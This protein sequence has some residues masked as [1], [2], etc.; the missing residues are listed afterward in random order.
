MRKLL[1]VSLAAF[2]GSL[3]A[4]LLVGIPLAVRAGPGGGTASE[5][6]DTNGDGTLDISD[7]VYLL[8]HLFKGGPAPAACADSPELV[9]RVEALEQQ[10]QQIGAMVDMLSTTVSAAKERPLLFAVNSI[11]GP[12]G[13]LC[14][15]D[16]Q[17]YPQVFEAPFV[18]DRPGNL[19]LTI[20]AQVSTTDLPNY[21]MPRLDGGLSTGYPIGTLS[22]DALVGRG[23]SAFFLT[24]VIPGGLPGVHTLRLDAFTERC[25]RSFWAGVSSSLVTLEYLDHQ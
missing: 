23:N 13:P 11:S 22:S 1:I 19:L 21:I 24:V 15:G 3:L 16:R 5:N 10:A 25:P 7:A 18:T 12:Q 8:L 2:S 17:L 4:V 20:T 6:G 9:R 14:D